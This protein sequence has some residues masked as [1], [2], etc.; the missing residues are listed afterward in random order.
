MP[1][2]QRINVVVERSGWTPP[3]ISPEAADMMQT[4]THLSALTSAILDAERIAPTTQKL[5]WVEVNQRFSDWLDSETRRHRFGPQKRKSVDVLFLNST[6]SD[7]RS[8]RRRTERGCT[9]HG[10]PAGFGVQRSVICNGC[11]ARGSID[12]CCRQSGTA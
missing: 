6:T 8:L 11:R 7:R 2:A 5:A 12:R 3:T 9:R 1:F 10:C 4:L